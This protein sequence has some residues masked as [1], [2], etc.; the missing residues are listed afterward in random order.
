MGGKSAPPSRCGRGPVSRLPSGPDIGEFMELRLKPGAWE[1][2]GIL[3][4][5]CRVRTSTLEQLLQQQR[6]YQADDLI[7]GLM[8][9]LDVTDDP[10]P[11]LDTLRLLL[12][13]HYPFDGQQTG[14]CCFRD[15]HGVDRIFHAGRIDPTQPLVTWQR[16]D[17]IIAGAQPSHEP[18]RMLVGAPGPISLH[19]ARCILSLSLPSYMGEPFDSFEGARTSCGR[20]AVFYSWERGEV[21]PIRWDDGLDGEALA[22]LSGDAS[23]VSWLPPNQLAMQV[24]IA[25]GY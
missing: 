7:L 5:G 3:E 21:T 11:A 1:E 6:T 8:D 18:G 24:A 10:Q 17:W 25:A 14:H 22:S 16:R 23:D 15:E 19:T 2:R 12:D 9:W 13:R 20:T 4:E